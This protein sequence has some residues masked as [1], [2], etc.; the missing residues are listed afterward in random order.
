VQPEAWQPGALGDFHYA[1]GA[2]MPDGT[3]VVA[4]A[5]WATPTLTIQH[6]AT[7]GALL[8]SYGATR[9]DIA[10]TVN[11]IPTTDGATI[12]WDS[13]TTRHAIP[14]TSS[15]GSLTV[16]AAQVTAANYLY[17]ATTHLA[18]D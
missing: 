1:G 4:Y 6:Y 5:D 16:G 9:G 3:V 15:N 18:A 17:N 2:A 10:D 8:G 11:T 14:V 13:P 12:L 7:D